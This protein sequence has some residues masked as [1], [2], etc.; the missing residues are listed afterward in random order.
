M[1]PYQ[2]MRLLEKVAADFK[3]DKIEFAAYWV[4]RGMKVFEGLLA[5]SKGKY[6]F[7]D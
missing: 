2:N 4:N 3:A 1:H 7:G 6:C 5:K